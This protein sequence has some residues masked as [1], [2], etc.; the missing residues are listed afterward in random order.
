M[1]TKQE[2]LTEIHEELLEVYDDEATDNSSSCY[3]EIVLSNSSGLAKHVD[4]II[5]DNRHAMIEKIN[6]H[7]GTYRSSFK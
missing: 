3:V 1:R 5:R 7:A 4:G 6:I 2:S